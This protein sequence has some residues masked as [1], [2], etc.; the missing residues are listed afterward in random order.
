[1]PHGARREMLVCPRGW[2]RGERGP[3]EEQLRDGFSLSFMG[4]G[5]ASYRLSGAGF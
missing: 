1:M 2:R 5:A 4:G 3:R